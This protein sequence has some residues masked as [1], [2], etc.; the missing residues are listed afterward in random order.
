MGESMTEKRKQEIMETAVEF[1]G[2]IVSMEH[3]LQVLKDAKKQ[4][5][6]I[7][8][9]TS[10]GKKLYALIDDEDSCY[11][12]VYGM[13]KAE[14]QE[15]IAKKEEETVN[16]EMEALEKVP[17]RVERGFKIIDRE[18][19]KWDDCVVVRSRGMFFGED[20]DHALDVMEI[21][22]SGDYEAAYKKLLDAGHSRESWELIRSIIT[23]FMKNGPK[24]Y[25]YVASTFE[26]EKD[27]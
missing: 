6:N 16:M 23:T 4:K 7:Y 17:A 1:A 3:A 26:D 15:E 22:K 18:H 8:V 25:E 11:Q 10:A 12:K 19:K 21:I 2:I 20:I 24:F 5:S 27:K 14:K 13:T 9:E